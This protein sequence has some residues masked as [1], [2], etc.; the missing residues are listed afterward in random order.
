[1]LNLVNVVG[2]WRQ[3]AVLSAATGRD[4]PRWMAIRP[5]MTTR[6][7]RGNS[8][9]SSLFWQLSLRVCSGY[10]VQACSFIEMPR[11]RAGVRVA[12]KDRT[13]VWQPTH[14]R[15]PWRMR[16][17]KGQ[18]LQTEITR[19]DEDAAPMKAA[20]VGMA[21]RRRRVQSSVRLTP[22]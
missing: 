14:G 4:R 5:K 20:S 17:S 8:S 7:R 18:F 19:D 15:D 12:V 6:Q 22:C 16:R 13:T 3:D 21:V 11:L 10:H 2:R 9:G 1:M